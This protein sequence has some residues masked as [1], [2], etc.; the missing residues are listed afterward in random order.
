MGSQPYAPQRHEGGIPPTAAGNTAVSGRRPEDHRSHTVQG[1]P[2]AA[3]SGDGGRRCP[4]SPL[5]PGAPA[6][7]FAVDSKHHRIV[8]EDGMGVVVMIDSDSRPGDRHRVSTLK[9]EFERRPVPEGWTFDKAFV[10]VEQRRVVGLAIAEQIDAALLMD[11]DF[12]ELSS[13][14]PAVCGIQSLWVTSGSP[15]P[16]CVYKRLVDAARLHLVFGYVVPEEKVAF[17]APSDEVREWVRAFQER[18]LVY[19]RA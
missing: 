12:T 10:L 19:H 3:H 11:A 16:H 1:V 15:D 8:A 18:P 2:D 17:N 4:R 5:P 7:P 13:T 14:V 9:A 6:L